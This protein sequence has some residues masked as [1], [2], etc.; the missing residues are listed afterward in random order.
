M[1]LPLNWRP[2]A[3]HK[4]GPSQT[5]P[6]HNWPWSQSVLGMIFAL[7]VLNR[8]RRRRRASS[9]TGHT[10]TMSRITATGTQWSKNGANQR[11]VTVRLPKLSP[12]REAPVA[13]DME[14]NAML[15][16]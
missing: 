8:R 3:N 11:I 14:M 4:T 5:Q 13:Y 15:P 6:T 12:R 10:S 2:H 9:R 16:T 7:G 1:H